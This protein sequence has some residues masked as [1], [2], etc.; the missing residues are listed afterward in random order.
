MVRL[1]RDAATLLS[2]KYTAAWGQR[3]IKE[4]DLYAG[5]EKDQRITHLP[6]DSASARVVRAHIA[7]RVT[8]L[9]EMLQQDTESAVNEVLFQHLHA[10]MVDSIRDPEKLG[11]L[12]LVAQANIGGADTDN[13]SSLFGALLDH[14]ALHIGF[15]MEKY[16][17]DK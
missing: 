8:A 14:F 4:W 3:Y 9:I 1:L 2:L 15:A 6:Y 11:T 7:A 10:A 16:G 12:P 13:P 17:D 5:I